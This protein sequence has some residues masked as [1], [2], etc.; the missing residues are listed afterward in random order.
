MPRSRSCAP[1]L[2]VTHGY[3][4]LT[5]NWATGG[6]LAEQLGRRFA[7]V[8]LVRSGDEGGVSDEFTRLLSDTGIF[9]VRTWD[10][11]VE[12]LEPALAVHMQDATLYF[13]P[14]FP[15]LTYPSRS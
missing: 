13:Q 4:E 7:L 14:A 6:A 1:L 9:T 15:G 3:Y 12:S 5:R 10:D 8:K 2:S 11:L